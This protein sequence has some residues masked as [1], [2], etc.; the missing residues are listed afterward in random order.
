M[1]GM[2]HLAFILC[3]LSLVSCVDSNRTRLSGFEPPGDRLTAP[4]RTVY[5]AEVDLLIDVKDSEIEIPYSGSSVD[6]DD[7][8]SCGL[9]IYAGTILSYSI[10]GG[11]LKIESPEGTSVFTK[12]N[13][14]VS[15]SL[16]GVWVSTATEDNWKIETTLTIRDLRDLQIKKTCTQVAK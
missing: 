5:Q 8:F 9:D 12:K 1:V 6:E 11:L 7:R 2:K 10:V 13:S 16:N 3:C 4:Q 14:S 15:K